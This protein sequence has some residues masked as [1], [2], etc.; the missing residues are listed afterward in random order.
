MDF[1]NRLMSTCI[2]TCIVFT[3]LALSD[4]NAQPIELVG[5]NNK[6]AGKNQ[7][8]TYGPVKPT[9]TLWRI[10]FN[11]RPD[12]K[13]SVDQVL[14]AIFMANP[15]AFK[16]NDIHSI[17]DGSTITIPSQSDIAT[18]TDAAAKLRIANNEQLKTNQTSVRQA[19]P[20]VITKPVDVNPEPVETMR[21]TKSS[22][23][24]ELSDPQID[25]AM[26]N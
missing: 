11:N 5:P 17:I 4:V 7:A 1:I 9:D 26:T 2:S 10:A 12:P 19:T 3:L 20:T 22:M 25:N 15:Q 21:D 13:L 14:I 18:I 6:V 23:K 8:A 16:N 24:E